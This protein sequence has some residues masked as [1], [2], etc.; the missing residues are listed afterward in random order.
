MTISS[1]E[2]KASPADNP[3]EGIW[4][5]RDVGGADSPVTIRPGVLFRSSELSGL[6]PA[7][8]QT[9]RAFGV[10]DLYDLRSP[11]EIARTGSDRVDGGIRV[12]EVPFATPAAG[13]ERAPHEIAYRQ[14]MLESMTAGRGPDPASQVEFMLA[15]YRRF[16]ELPGTLV[17]LKAVVDQLSSGATALV[18]C[19][20]GKDRTGLLVGLVLSSVGIDYADIAADYLRS[21]AAIGAMR[22]HISAQMNAAE[23]ELAQTMAAMLSDEVLGVREEYLDT[24]FRQ[25][26]NVFGSPEAMLAAAGVDDEG[27][28]ALR[29]ALT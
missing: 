12:H 6:T 21:N 7:G 20:A 9:L 10:T 24:G 22:A 28:I 26:T 16:P 2:S 4:N 13:E 17:A 11:T 8:A 19:A 18:H 15:E 23:P 25:V 1:A 29:A 14:M 27:L 3:V 5:F